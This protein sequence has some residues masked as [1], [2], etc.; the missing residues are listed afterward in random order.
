MKK[1]TAKKL[2]QLTNKLY[3]KESLS[4]DKTRSDLWEKE[5]IEFTANIKPG[6]SVLDLGCGNARLYQFLANKSIKYLGVDVSKKLIALNKKKYGNSDAAVGA[7]PRFEVGDG[8]KFPPKADQR[9][10]DKFDYVIS[11]AVLHHIPSEELQIKF[12]KNI[13]NSLKPNG[14]LLVTVWNRYQ[15]RYQKYFKTKKPYKD[16]ENADLLVPWKQSGQFRYIHAF[17]P[18]ELKQLAQK[19]GFKKI[20]VFTSKHGKITN[21]D[22]AL[23]IYLQAER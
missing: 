12:L 4:F 1:T 3:D 13:Y 18:D 21:L 9:V 15:Q 7:N 2:M 14:Q 16:M 11:I 8:L 23:N 19:A 10:A 22:Q 6:S 20:K 5:I 17:K